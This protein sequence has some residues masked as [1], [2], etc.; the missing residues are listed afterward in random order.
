MV[1]KMSEQGNI[2]TGIARIYKGCVLIALGFWF[3]CL[4]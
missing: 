2:E 1:K 3:L 4:V